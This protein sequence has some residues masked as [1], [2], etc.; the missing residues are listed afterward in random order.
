MNK[1]WEDFSIQQPVV[2]RMLVNSIK[3]NRLAH[4]YLLEGKR[5]TG[6][7]EIAK[8]LAKTLFCKDIYGEMNPCHT[9]VNCRRI[10]SGNHPDVH[11]I[12]PDGLSIKKQQ[13][14]LL[15]EEFSKTGVESKQKFYIIN[16]ADKM[17]INA[18]NSLLKFLEEP[19]EGTTAV[20]LTEQIN[21]MID[22]I[23]SRCQTLSTMTVSKEILSEQLTEAGINPVLARVVVQL[24]NSIDQAQ[25]LAQD[26]W[27]AEA[28][29]VVLQLCEVLDSSA[30]LFFIQEKWIQH[31]KER[32]QVEIGLDLLLLYY[33]DI[34]SFIIGEEDAV[35]YRDILEQMKQR[36]LQLSQKSIVEKMA[37]ILE[38]KK[39]LNANVQGQL[40]MEQ[41]VLKLQ[42]G[43]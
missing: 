13:I 12:E 19:N 22:T 25:S 42:E 29:K 27:F 21:K 41:L 35:V 5:G 39:R 1:T 28:R 7:K 37:A 33:R 23:I 34:L 11:I 6:K 3:K 43:S 9:C 8:F 15:Q 18:S 16:H 36:A 40:M 24:T 14:Q 20:L 2:T 26:D 31:F 10:E 30:G 38:A 17:T 32:E 4:A